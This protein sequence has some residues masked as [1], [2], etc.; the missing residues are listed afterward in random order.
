MHFYLHHGLSVVHGD[1]VDC[2]GLLQILLV[3]MTRGYV[4]M[5]QGCDDDVDVPLLM[6]MD[7]VDLL[8]YLTN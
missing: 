2:D 7:F 5:S 6:E 8:V 1:H 4:Q 3:Q